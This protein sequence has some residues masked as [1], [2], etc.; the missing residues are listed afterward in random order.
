[1]T[2]Q[3]GSRGMWLKAYAH[4]HRYLLPRR[5]G[6]QHHAELYNAADWLVQHQ[7]ARW[8]SYGSNAAPG[9]VLTGR[10]WPSA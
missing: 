5:F 7:Y 4:G 3:T 8:I 2:A 1:M 9:I 6:R 10:P